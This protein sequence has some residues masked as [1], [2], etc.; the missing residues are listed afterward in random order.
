MSFPHYT[1]S[2]TPFQSFLGIAQQHAA[3]NGVCS[4]VRFLPCKGK[5]VLAEA[6]ALKGREGSNKRLMLDQFG[7][8]GGE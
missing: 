5:R 2:K 4:K 6:S 3:Q 7:G 8:T 1:G